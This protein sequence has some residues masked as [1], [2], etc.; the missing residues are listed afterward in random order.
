MLVF[1]KIMIFHSLKTRSIKG[2]TLLELTVAAAVSLTVLGV[3]LGVMVEMRRSMLGDRT[4]IVA[5]DN[6]RIA[7]DLIGQD[8]KQSGER[9][10]SDN[11]LPG[12]SIIPGA[13]ATDP[14]TLTLQRKLLTETLPLCQDIGST[15]TTIDVSVVTGS[16]ILN[17]P[18][19]YK[20]PTSGELTALSTLKPTNNLRAWRTFRCTQDGSSTTTA[21]DP[22]T[23]TTSGSK[24]WAYIYDPGNK[25]GEFFQYSLEESGNCAHTSLT[26]QTCQRIKRVGSTW[27]YSYTF[28][29]ITGTAANQPQLYLLE[30]R[31]YSLTPDT[32]TSRTDDYILQLS[33]NGQSAQRI[34]NQIRSFNVWAKVPDSFSLVPFKAPSTWG[35]AAG[36]STGPNPAFSTQWYCSKFIGNSSSA[37]IASEIS[38]GAKAVMD[39]Q[40]LQGIRITLT[41]INPNSQLLKV[42]EASTNNV[43]KLSSEFLPRNVASK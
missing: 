35:C 25:R 21:S 20:A 19:S 32:I 1:S 3:S 16:P 5:N 15:T 12:I 40:D 41:G 42:D 29:P 18:Y 2:F 27:T 31:E 36:G 23:T 8:I 22:C 11:L 38:G 28:N 9:L 33:V 24:A 39:W 37:A 4:R 14:S 13:S 34:G 26:G 17:C 6:L 43:L 7:S 10:E 30:Q